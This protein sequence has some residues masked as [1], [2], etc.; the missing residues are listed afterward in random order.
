MVDYS[1]LQKRIKT[2]PSVIRAIKQARK[3]YG[4][5]GVNKAADALAKAISK[6][7]E[8][9]ALDLSD[10]ELAEFA[11]SILRRMYSTGQKTVLQICEDLQGKLL[12]D[13][14]VGLAPASV[15]ADAARISNLVQ[16]FSEAETLDDVRFLLGEDVVQNI[17]RG[18]VND[19]IKA[20]A[21]NLYRAGFDVVVARTDPGCCEWCASMT[22]AYPVG[23]WPDDF[24]RVH[25]DCSCSFDYR[26]RISGVHQKISFSSGKKQV[27]NL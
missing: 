13:L 16:K 10:A 7:V 18:A 11:A 5:S 9:A 12:S 24:W 15:S 23:S 20:N 1:T 21:D 2:D 27:E 3:A 4:F 25:K 17:M 22:G 26:S 8:E 19:S 14:G 6:A